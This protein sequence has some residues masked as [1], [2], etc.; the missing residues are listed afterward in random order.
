MLT[1][2]H[3]DWNCQE[4]L[5]HILPGSSSSAGRR[6]SHQLQR[7]SAA[8]STLLGPTGT[9]C[10]ETSISASPFSPA[11]SKGSRGFLWVWGEFGGMREVVVAV[12][13]CF[14]AFQ[15]AG[16]RSV[17]G[18]HPP[19]IRGWGQVLRSHTR[20]LPARK[21]T[22]GCLGRVHWKMA[23]LWRTGSLGVWLR[24]QGTFS[25]LL[26]RQGEGGV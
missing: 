5:H 2:T 26:M 18:A 6:L 24:H 3:P 13:L 7:P 25:N 4:Y 20:F 10:S 11:A 8:S 9:N 12:S 16:K 22:T 14:K 19:S 23:L 15:R 21:E 1:R 17:C